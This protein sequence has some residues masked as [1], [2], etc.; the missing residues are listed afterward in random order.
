MNCTKSGSLLAALL[1]MVS[2]GLQA[3]DVTITVNGRV[4]AKPCTVSVI[5]ANVDLGNLYT[6]N[7]FVE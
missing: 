6:Y 5:N 3:A 2:T 7:G 1:L 4:V